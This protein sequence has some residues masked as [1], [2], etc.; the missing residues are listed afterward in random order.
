VIMSRIVEKVTAFIIRQSTIGRELL[1]FQ[2]PHAGVQVPAGTVETGEQPEAAA[3]REAAEETG[4]SDFATCR[5]LGCATEQLPETRRVTLEATQVYARPDLTSSKWASIGRG[6]TVARL[7]Q[8][9]GFSQIHYQEF[10]R[11]PDPQYVSLSITGWVPDE[12]LADIQRR[13]F[14]LLEFEGQTAERW[15]VYTDNHHFT[16]FWAPLGALPEIISPQDKWLDFLPM[17]ELTG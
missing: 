9:E 5:Y 7:R 11:L 4:L 15:T 13:H 14:F 1:L 6:V 3:R 12:A 2:H 10:D 8:A 16:L 17:D